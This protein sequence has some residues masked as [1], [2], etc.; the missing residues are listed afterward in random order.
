[1]LGWRKDAKPEVNVARLKRKGSL[2]VSG[3]SLKRVVTST[4]LDVFF[5]SFSSRISFLMPFLRRKMVLKE[6]TE[7]MIQKSV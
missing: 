4:V 5:S 2:K 6:R 1:M 7:N 3:T